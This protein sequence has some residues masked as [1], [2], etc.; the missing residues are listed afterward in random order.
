MAG[1]HCVVSGTYSGRVGRGVFWPD[2]QYAARWNTT[3]RRRLT[4]D[5]YYA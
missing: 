1:G 5:T 4:L 2:S 3:V